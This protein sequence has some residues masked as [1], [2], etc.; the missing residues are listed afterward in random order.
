MLVGDW[1]YHLQDKRP[2][3]DHYFMNIAQAVKMRCNC[4]SAK[5][6]AIIVR[7]KIILST[8]YNGSPKGIKHCNS[9]GCKRCTTRHLGKMKSGVYS[10]PCIC[11]HAEE[12]AIVQAAYN[13]VSTNGATLYTSFT[14]CV[15]CA[16][17]IINAGIKRVVG[18]VLYPDDEGTR[19][20]KEAKIEFE[21][22]KD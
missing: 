10:E 5:K 12:N 7:D 9:G 6:G 2:D 14:P 15:N 17:M 8:G 13:G 21:I 19:I 1:I 18:K 4:L 20:L 16:G 3:W 11:A 22:L